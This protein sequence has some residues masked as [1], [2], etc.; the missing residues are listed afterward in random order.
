LHSSAVIRF[1]FIKPRLPGPADLLA[2]PEGGAVLLSVAERFMDLCFRP[3]GKPEACHRRQPALLLPILLLPVPLQAGLPLGCSGTSPPSRTTCRPTRTARMVGSSSWAVSSRQRGKRNTSRK[4]SSVPI[5]LGSRTG[6]GAGVLP[7]G[8]GRHQLLGHPLR[9]LKR[10]FV[11]A[12]PRHRL[13]QQG[14]P[15]IPLLLVGSDH[16][17]AGGIEK[18]AGVADSP[19]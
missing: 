5:S 13:P 19:T 10:V 4:E 16:H 11:T 14:Q 7:P 12:L 1:P 2:G 6:G 15:P 18:P 17:G 3:T 8:G 9:R